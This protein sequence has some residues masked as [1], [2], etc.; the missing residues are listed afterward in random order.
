MDAIAR[1][2]TKLQY[3]TAIEV[4]HKLTGPTFIYI[5]T[6]AHHRYLLEEIQTGTMH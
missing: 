3:R 4:Q 1:Y 5:N 6:F 2:T